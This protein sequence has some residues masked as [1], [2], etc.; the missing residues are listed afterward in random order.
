MLHLGADSMRVNVRSAFFR[1]SP[2]AVVH[3]FVSPTSQFMIDSVPA[4]RLDFFNRPTS[5][6]LV[7][8]YNDAS[9]SAARELKKAFCRRRQLPY[10]SDLRFLVSLVVLP[11]SGER[12]MIA[13]QRSGTVLGLPRKPTP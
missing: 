8:S 10:L 1:T 2:T 3:C 9:F 12:K 6:Y 5:T 11:C 13:N 7:L 4:A